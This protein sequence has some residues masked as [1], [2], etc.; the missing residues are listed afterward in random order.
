MLQSLFIL[1]EAGECI[2]EKHWRGITQRRVADFFW[3][4]VCKVEDKNDVLPVMSAG[5]HYLTNIYRDGLFILAVFTLEMA[6]LWSIEFM[7]RC[8]RRPALSP[9][10][11]AV[12]PCLLFL[13]RIP[14][15]PPLSLSL[16]P[17]LPPSSLARSLLRTHARVLVAIRY[18]VCHKRRSVCTRGP[19]RATSAPLL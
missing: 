12:P 9:P 2:I 5:A 10:S 18:L 11:L 4:Q 17:S 7:H 15:N 16:P 13:P 6:P 1:N 8:G 3:E 14:R 19:Y